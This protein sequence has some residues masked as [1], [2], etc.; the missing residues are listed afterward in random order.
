MSKIV[1]VTDTNSSLS[2]ALAARYDIRLVP[3][4]IHLDGKSIEAVTEINDSQLFEIVDRQGKIPDSSSPPPGKF[5]RFFR[6]AKEEAVSIIL[7]CLADQRSTRGPLTKETDQIHHE[8]ISMKLLE[9]YLQKQKE[10]PLVK[11]IS[12]HDIMKK[13]KI[14]PS[15]I[16][17]EML[18]EVEEKHALGKIRTKTEAMKLVTDFYKKNKNG[19]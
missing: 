11:L 5:Y 13:L 12:G 15:S 17:G 9:S 4:T 18:K 8:K 14:K 19:V 6:D 3:I 1:I 2:P 7:L 10:K 16:V